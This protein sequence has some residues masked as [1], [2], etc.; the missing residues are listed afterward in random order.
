M[1]FPGSDLADCRMVWQ[2]V[3]FS[4]GLPEKRGERLIFPLW[5]NRAV[6][7]AFT[8]AKYLDRLLV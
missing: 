4:G 3:A 6:D 7:A 8:G 1:R 5:A 2:S